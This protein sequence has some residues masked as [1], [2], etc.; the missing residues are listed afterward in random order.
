MNFVEKDRH[1]DYYKI[2]MVGT[3]VSAIVFCLLDAYSFFLNGEGT[4]AVKILLLCVICILSQITCALLIKNKSVFSFVSPFVLFLLFSFGSIYVNDMRYIFI[5]NTSICVIAAL[6]NRPK[7]LF[8]FVLVTN[9]L[10]FLEMVLG[11]FNNDGLGFDNEGTIYLHWGMYLCSS[12]CLCFVTSFAQEKSSQTIASF[13]QLKTLMSSSTNYIAMIDERDC[14]IAISDLFVKLGHLKT[15]AAA[16]GRPI[17]DILPDFELKL[18]VSRII[19]MEDEYHGLKKINI[20]GELRTLKVGCTKFNG[21]TEGKLLY[22][23]D[24]TSE[25]AAKEAEEANKSKSKFLAQMSHE[26]RTPMNTILG[27]SELM[28]TDNLDSV[29]LG[30]FDDIKK[31]GK[32]L[33]G[34]INDILDFSKIESGKFEIIPTH[35]N[36]YA[37]YDNVSSLNK[38]VAES[39]ELKFVSSFAQNLPEVVYADEIRM[40]QIWTNIIANAIKYTRHGTVSF[41][42][43][44]EDRDGV[45]YIVSKTTDTGIGIKEED[46]PK[47]FGSFQQL[48]S[49]KNKSITGTGLGLAI[50]KQLVEL[51]DGSLDVH[52]VYGEGSEFTVNLPLILGDYRKVERN[53]MSN[54][55][56]KA[57]DD[58]KVLVVDDTEVNLRVAKGFLQKFNIDPDLSESGEDAIRKILKT[59]YDI[60]FMDHMMPEMD[61]IET[62]VNIR[63]LGERYKSLVIVALSANAISGMRE[64]F[65]ASGMDD[66]VSKPIDIGLL[67]N[68]LEKWLP[69][70]KIV[71]HSGND[72]L[73]NSGNSER[74]KKDRRK[75]YDRRIKYQSEIETMELHLRNIKGFY[76]RAALKN[77][78]SVDVFLEVL[79]IFVKTVPNILEQIETKNLFDKISLNYYIVLVHGLKSSLRLLGMESIGKIAED[80]EFAGKDGNIDSIKSINSEFIETLKTIIES[81]KS[82]LQ[83]IEKTKTKIQKDKP[84][85]ELLTRLK[86]A[87]EQMDIDLIDAIVEELEKYTYDED[88]Q[89]ITKI[90]ELLTVS[91]FEGIAGLL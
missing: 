74:R 63:N 11:F 81:L 72:Y 6:Y 86:K 54:I 13:D 76:F 71:R 83:T 7:S 22:M 17:I 21:T 65:I 82:F 3:I 39:K 12:V 80:L 34:L 75:N 64:M 10:I 68:V 73:L 25:I 49:E 66:F 85:D 57:S 36:L 77:A 56:I 4:L 58:A 52:S 48:D 55:L 78:G 53:L 23:N 15:S 35:F 20:A 19:N 79:S 61:G 37:L 59:D 24:I 62:T 33:L 29:Q 5:A 2:G 47:L 14:I 90:K 40:R 70:E 45:S 27:M 44:A 43:Y 28:R 41:D 84:D 16:L 89:L 46:F 67:N 88:A 8:Y 42:V 50:T 87:A 38:F 91:D 30:Y 51:M 18:Y 9:I 26:I 60:V 69:K 32:A 1:K 31:M